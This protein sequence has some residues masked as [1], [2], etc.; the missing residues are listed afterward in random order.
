MS[1]EGVFERSS[2]ENN[3]MNNTVYL[4]R[5]QPEYPDI[6]C[7]PDR[8]PLFKAL[9]RVWLAAGMDIENPFEQWLAPGGTALIKPNWVMDINPRGSSI[10]CLVTHPTMI[11]HALLWCARAMEGHGTIVIGDCPLQDCDFENL[12]RLNSISAIT[13]IAQN[14][15][16]D[17]E[18]LVEDWRLTKLQSSKRGAF[19]FAAQ[20]SAHGDD[21]AI[22][23]QYTLVDVGENSFLEDTAEFAERYRVANYNPDLMGE[24][25]RPGKHEYLLTRRAFQADLMVNLAKLKTHKKAGL[26]G[27]LKN[28]VGLNGHKEFLPH[29]ITGSH[30]AGG[31]CYSRP[32]AFMGWRESLSDYYWRNQSSIPRS[33][34]KGILV[35]IGLLR[36]LSDLTGGD[37]ITSGGWSG[38]ETVWRMT[39][40]LNHALYFGE[41]SPKKIISIVDG[42][43]AGEGDGPLWP[44]AKPL[45]TILVGENPACVDATIARIMGY[46]IS[47]VPTVHH[48]IY[49][50][51]SKFATEGLSAISVVY[52]PETGDFSQL[53]LL[54]VPVDSFV[55]PRYWRRAESSS[56]GDL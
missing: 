31:D 45:G 51:R 42:I 49:D 11:K 52:I 6:A 24:H 43:I 23:R 17:I 16:P 19:A 54:D 15:Y 53:S 27:A 37:G 25:H 34:R 9:Q 56:R 39:L 48:A 38:N 41:H 47:R 28:L 7:S 29:H 14:R 4:S 35:L 13:E 33:T 44:T 30:L 40:D 55:K 26:T 46:N 10:D 8:D 1:F 21:E 3:E 36:R 50:R 12:L 22:E 18:I 5:S 32:N 2:A 20:T